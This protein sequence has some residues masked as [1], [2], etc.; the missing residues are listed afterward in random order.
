MPQRALMHLRNCPTEAGLPGYEVTNEALL[1]AVIP[2][3]CGW[4]VFCFSSLD[5]ASSRLYAYS[6]SNSVLSRAQCRVL[7]MKRS[8]RAV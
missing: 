7:D 5:R 8:A 1:T 6:S 4:L 2:R 3:R